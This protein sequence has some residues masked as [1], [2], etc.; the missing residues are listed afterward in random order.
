MDQINYSKFNEIFSNLMSECES[1]VKTRYPED[2]LENK[3]Y[4]DLIKCKDLYFKSFNTKLPITKDNKFV[5][6]FS[7]FLEENNVLDSD[8]I[9]SKSIFYLSALG[10]DSGPKL[11]EYN[12]D[13]STFYSYSIH[14]R[15]SEYELTG[16]L[17]DT[18]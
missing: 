12:I 8:S 1:V 16:G 15:D 2:Y 9:I 11:V 5:T 6:M 3:V 18:F 13:F 14:N 10:K 7:R 17:Y 4:K